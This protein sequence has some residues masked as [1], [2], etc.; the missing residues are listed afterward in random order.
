MANSF[1]DVQPQDAL[2]M[3]DQDIFGDF[4][5]Q[6]GLIGSAYE[7]VRWGVLGRYTEDSCSFST[8]N[9]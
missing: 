3:A 2:E 6:Q 8:F 7:I 5:L 9:H 1:I 4:N